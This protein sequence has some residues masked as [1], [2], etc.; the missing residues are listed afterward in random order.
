MIR[1]QEK[2][3]NVNEYLVC[4]FQIVSRLNWSLK[5]YS[6]VVSKS[7][8]KWY[9][10]SGTHEDD[11]CSR[12]GYNW[13]ILQVVPWLF[14][15]VVY[16]DYHIVTSETH[17]S[18]IKHVKWWFHKWSSLWV[19]I[20]WST[21]PHIQ[22]LKIIKLD[23]PCYDIGGGA[24]PIGIKVKDPTWGISRATGGVIP[25]YLVVSIKNARLKCQP[26]TPI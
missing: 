4:L 11:K 8:Y 15:H 7:T 14:L 23:D 9:P 26:S 20:K 24:P 21:F 10:T 2:D 25:T 17:T 18:D 22:E 16:L 3:I 5:W 1:V 19:I 6:Q 12:N 13:Q